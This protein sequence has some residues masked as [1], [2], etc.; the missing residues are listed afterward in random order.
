MSLTRPPILAVTADKPALAGFLLKAVTPV[1]GLHKEVTE[2]S[3]M[4]SK[5][6][7]MLVD[8][9]RQALSWVTLKIG[10]TSPRVC[11]YAS[12]R[13]YARQANDMSCHDVTHRCVSCYVLYILPLPA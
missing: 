8:Y 6:K 10:K 13:V 4:I 9:L 12:V 1:T 5:A 11:A 3:G 2:G 7:Y